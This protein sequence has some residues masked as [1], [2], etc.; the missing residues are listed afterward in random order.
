MND[1]RP[2]EKL[3]RHAAKKRSDEAGPPP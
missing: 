3:L 1:E 2:I